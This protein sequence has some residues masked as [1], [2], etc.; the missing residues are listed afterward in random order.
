M[1][2]AHLWVV[3]LPVLVWPSTVVAISGIALLAAPRARH[4]DVL[5]AIAEVISA[6]R[7]P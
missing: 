3:L 1:Q 4:A 2:L 6:A 5:R 7:R